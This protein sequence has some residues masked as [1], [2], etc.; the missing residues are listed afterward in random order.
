MSYSFN[1]RAANRRDALRA[2]C[3]KFEEVIKVQPM[4]ERD[5]AAVVANV[6]SALCLLSDD[7][8]KDIMVSC[9]GYLSWHHDGDDVLGQAKVTSAS[10]SCHV[11][12]MYRDPA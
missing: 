10:L 11:G 2:A 7:D 3:D 9:N 8:T 6:A 12:F 5:R 4:H 1:V